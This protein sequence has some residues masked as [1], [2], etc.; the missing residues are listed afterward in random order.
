M[1]LTQLNEKDNYAK[2]HKWKVH[3]TEKTEGELGKA[4]I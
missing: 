4:K 1:W 3:G 2:S